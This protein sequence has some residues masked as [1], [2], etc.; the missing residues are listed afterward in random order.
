MHMLNSLVIETPRLRLRPFRESDLDDL[1]RI[2]A[3]PVVARFLNYGKPMSREE[4]WRQ[5]ATFLGH[6]EMRGYSVLAI[7]DRA[8]GD[9][10]GRSGIWYPEGWPMVE[11]GWV[12]DPRRRGEGIA[13]EAGRASLDWC[14]AHLDVDEVCSII[15]PDNIAS[16]RVAAK[17]G[18]RIDRRID[19]F[20]G[21]PADVWIHRQ[22]A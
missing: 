14:F 17:L 11:V 13:G 7:E 20:M 12:V 5:V 21:S 1:S 2:N 6:R 4:T 8:T 19:N 22:P 16:A 3:D 15:R 18:A 10:L 9:L